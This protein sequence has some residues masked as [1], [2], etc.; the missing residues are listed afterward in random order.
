M[1]LPGPYEPPWKRLG[2]D[3]VAIGAWLLL[4]L[5]ELGRR[6]GEG[7]LPVP[8]FW[9][10]RWPQLF[11]PLML[12]I[13]LLAPVAGVNL[14]QHQGAQGILPEPEAAPVSAPPPEPQGIPDTA[15]EEE[16]P[17]QD[18]AEPP[19]DEI[20]R[21]G[22][23]PEVPTGEESNEQSKES[24]EEERLR[25]QLNQGDQEN[26]LIAVRPDPDNATLTLQLDDAFQTLPPSSLQQQAERW[27]ARAAEWGYSHLELV[28]SR[29]LLVGREAQVGEGMILFRAADAGGSPATDGE[30]GGA[31]WDVQRSRWKSWW[32]SGVR[33]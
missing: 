21:G 31:G 17:Q 18:F 25:A 15:M 28:D 19:G 33:P 24:S 14:V 16:E 12:A 13:A 2:E 9:P 29:G 27:Q 32:S 10:R 26:L 8:A 20:T 23:E 11:W 7:S 4:K 1:P 6:S 3:L 5:R 30:V 22:E